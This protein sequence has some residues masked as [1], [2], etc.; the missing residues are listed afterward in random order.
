MELIV[1]GTCWVFGDNIMGD[2]AVR[3]S[4][5]N[6][7]VFDP[8]ILREYCMTGYDSE[9]P[10]KVKKGD[11]I[12]AGG[13]FGC[14][15]VHNQFPLSLKGAGI[16]VVIAESFCRDFFRTLINLGYPIPIICESITKK[17]KQGN[18]VRVDLEKGE[19][20]NLTTGELIKI[21]P[22]PEMLIERI[23]AGG[24]KQY[25]KN[26]LGSSSK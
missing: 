13:N 21:S 11:L 16:P 17:V 25:L 22:L 6:K 26:K 24:T 7:Y 19:I 15:H 2:V 8:E 20:N 5:E 9:F 10:R 18:Q 4:K 12:I 14:G 3:Y 23:V 1:E